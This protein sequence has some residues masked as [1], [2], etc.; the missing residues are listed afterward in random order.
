M[1]GRAEIKV[2]REYGNLPLVECYPGQLNQVFMNLLS[3]AIDALE[4]LRTRK[5]PCISDPNQPPNPTPT[6]IIRTYIQEM[7]AGMSLPSASPHLTK[8]SLEPTLQAVIQIADNGSG[9]T[10]AVR[11]RLFDPFFTTKV[12]GKGTGLGLSIS[13][14]IVV[15]K[16]GGNIYCISAPAEGTE[17][18][19]EIPIS[20]KK[21]ATGLTLDNLNSF[22]DQDFIASVQ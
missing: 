9:M 8:Q 15:E 7:K 22:L 13:Y 14:Q 11:Q 12:V 17:F 5:T 3:N 21:T 6:I 2:I 19:I 10:E 16:H 4:G 1:P 18:V 20:Q